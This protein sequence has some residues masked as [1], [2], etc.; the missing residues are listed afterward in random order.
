MWG[1]KEQTARGQSWTQAA[2]A[3]A[4]GWEGGGSEEAGGSTERPESPG[5]ARDRAPREN[6]GT[7][8][9]PSSAGTLGFLPWHCPWH[10]GGGGRL[11]DVPWE[12]RH[13]WPGPDG[14]TDCRALAARSLGTSP[15]EEI[16][17]PAAGTP[18]PGAGVT[19]AK[20]GLRVC[21]AGGTEGSAPG[22]GL[23][24]ALYFISRPVP[25]EPLMPCVTAPTCTAGGWCWSG[26]TPR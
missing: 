14:S 26:Q 2:E 8:W 9:L 24:D 1:S 18:R 11:T 20:A 22:Q 25:R 23:A 17:G 3:G 4:G 7:A 21:S 10:P 15:T 5:P 16:D 12:R 13:A 6:E 19:G